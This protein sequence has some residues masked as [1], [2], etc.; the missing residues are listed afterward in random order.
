[1]EQHLN[2]IQKHTK[3]SAEV[4]GNA[5]RSIYSRTTEEVLNQLAAEWNTYDGLKK[6]EIA[7]KYAGRYQ[8]GRFHALMSELSK[9]S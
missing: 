3:E 8:S 6:N 9:E 1:M 5:L 4:I 2:F 7:V